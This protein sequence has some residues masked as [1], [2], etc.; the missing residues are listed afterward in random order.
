M[1]RI[2]ITGAA[3]FVGR[4]LVPALQARHT[5]FAVDRQIPATPGPAGATW[6]DC[7]LTAPLD[8]ARLPEQVDAV[9]HLA[10][11]RFY[12]Q[13]PARA[14]DIFAVNIQSTFNLLEYARQAGA[15]QFIFASSGGV[16][17][18]SSE[19]LVETSPLATPNFYITS[20]YAAELM[21]ANY[22]PFFRAAILR[23]FFIY[24]AGQE[25]MLIPNLMKRVLQHE[26]ITI[27][28]NPGMRL[29]PTHVDDV[30]R[31]FEPLLALPEPV[32]LNVAGDEAV[33]LT[34]L[35]KEIEI[36]T[37]QSARLEYAEAKVKGDLV[38][39]NTRMKEILGVYPQVSL[40]QGLK[41][42]LTGPEP[43]SA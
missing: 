4:H 32:L 5:L 3:G 43:G 8:R 39:D 1:K 42:M 26:T 14:D 25:G 37:R 9:I 36:V 28:G 41:T 21:I 38:A 40:R 29:T 20:K 23:F 22:R 7:D 17:E 2:L 35:V 34:E 33:T 18:Q 6:I 19:K 24:G 13:F 16:Y 31:V 15:Q 12:R 10:Q 30:V 27:E 11:S